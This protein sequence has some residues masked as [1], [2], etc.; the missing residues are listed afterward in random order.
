MDKQTYPKEGK[1]RVGNGEK[2][3]SPYHNIAILSNAWVRC[4]N[5][6]NIHVIF[7]DFFSAYFFYL[8]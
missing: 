4:A 8:F 6:S 1:T 2:L 3:I 5:K 7:I